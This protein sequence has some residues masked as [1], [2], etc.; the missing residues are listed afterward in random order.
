MTPLRDPA[1][2][3]TPIDQQR[4][5]LDNARLEQRRAA[6]AAR[7]AHAK[8][9]A[10]TRDNSDLNRQELAKA[11]E[12]AKAAGAA[13]DRIRNR[14]RSERETLIGDLA[15]WLAPT[16]EQ[17]IARLSGTMPLVFLP[18]RIET[19]FTRDA[20]LLR[21]Y[22]DDILS[23]SFE[24]ELTDD[25]IAD[26]Q[27]FWATAWPG[28]TEERTAWQVLVNKIG[29]GRAAWVAN[30]MT[31]PNIA[32]RP[33][34][35]PQPATPARREASWTL[36]AEAR[37]LPDRWHVLL[38]S[39]SGERIVS[40]SAIHE[41]LSLTFSPDP[42]DPASPLGDD[43][44]KLSD[45]VRW[46]VDFQEALK[47][48]MALQ[49]SLQGEER[50][51]FS[52]I[53]V[54]GVKSSLAPDVS[55]TGLA[56]MLEHHRYGR[57]VALVPQGTPTN[58]TSSGA[59][60]FPPPDPG[61]Q[62]SFAVER[63]GITVAS[64]R[65]GARFASA[66][67]FAPTAATHLEGADGREFERA[68][69]MARGLWPVT[70]G[71]F[72]TEL[73][74][75]V[76][77]DDDIESARQFFVNHVR[78]RGPLPAFRVG[79]TPYGIV[80]AS[81]LTNWESS[82]SAS[83]AERALPDTFRRARDLWLSKASQIPHVGRSADPDKDL[84]EILATDASAREVRVRPVMGED[85]TW[86]LMGM[87]GWPDAWAYWFDAG[88]LNATLLFTLL[89]HP[90]WRPKVARLNFDQNAWPFK[91]HLVTEAPVSETDGLSPN[92]IDWIRT[93][94]VPDLIGQS[95]PA[96]WDPP[97]SLLYRLL[98]H[99][100]LLEYQSTSFRLGLRL[101]VFQI[102]QRKE[103]EITGLASQPA[104]LDRVQ[105]MM[106]PI[107]G[108]T[109]TA[110][111]HSF[112][113]DPANA[114]TIVSLFPDEPVVGLRDALAIL[115]IASTAEL[116]RLTGETLDCASHRLDAWITA[117]ATKRLEEM[118]RSSPTGCYLAGY[119]WVEN[120]K[121]KPAGSEHPV[122]LSDGS[123]A[124]RQDGN[125]GYVQAPSMT[126]AAAAAILR[127]GYLS[128]TG[129]DRE[130]YAVDLSS[131]QVRSARFVLDAVREGQSIG[132][133]FGYQFERG[134]HDR[135]LDKWI[136]PFR[137]RYPL[138][139]AK[140]GD[141]DDY[142]D[143]SNPDQPR[144]HIA[145]R[146]VVDGLELRTAFQNNQIPWG[147]F[148]LPTT[149][150][151]RQPIEEELA[152]LDRTVDS[153][154][155]LLL[156]E[157]V[158]QLVK[159]SPS[160]AAA[161]LDAMAQGTVRPPDP[162]IATQ[163]RRGT[164][165]TH[166]V[167]LFTGGNGKALPAGFA[168]A[169]T[170]RALIEP[171]L[172]AW[173]GQLF[174]PAA[175]YKC[176]VEFGKPDAP[177]GST[178]V[179]LDQLALRPIDVLTLVRSLSAP[180]PDST[181][182]AA[183]ELDRRVLEV[184]HG[185]MGLTEETQARIQYGR[186]AAGF[187]PATERTFSDLLELARKADS[188]ITQS[189]PLTPEDLVAED[190]G[191]DAKA[192]D[193]HLAEGLTRAQNARQ[194]LFVAKQAMDPE[195]AAAEAAAEAAPFDLT[196]LR[197]ALRAVAEIGVNGAYPASALE[198]TLDQRKQLIAQAGSV[199]AEASRRLKQADATLTEAAKPE[200]AADVRFLL[201][202]V[203]DVIDSICGAAMPFL[204]RFDPPASAELSNALAHS[205]TAAFIDADPTKRRT[206]IRGFERVAA[207]VRSPLDHWRRLEIVA[208]SLGRQAAPRAIA[209]LP[210]QAGA[211]WAGLP[212]PDETKRPSAGDTSILFYC[213]DTPD[214]TVPWCGLLLDHWTEYIPIPTEQTGV[215]FHY[216]DPGA[217]A[218]Q[219]ILLAVPPV[220]NP[221]TWQLSWII[222]TLKESLD[223]AKVRAVDGELLGDVSQLLPAIELADSTA[224]VTIR[225]SFSS[226][227][228]R[229]AISIKART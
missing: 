89:G 102:D 127:N 23:D 156:A 46:T 178:P 84:M 199:S 125:G 183:S 144:E 82:R 138:V 85:S 10:L 59:A 50:A 185:L 38:Q 151:E 74:S 206:A 194:M 170:P 117:L 217:E 111:V 6:L 184:A 120:L 95:V 96:G 76:F 53:I 32:T 37:L 79:N 161:T 115:S 40:G 130:K 8:V 195:L 208:N 63:T 228:A 118:R 181:S 31:P 157:G 45:D 100:A 9:D 135:V 19:R 33:G 55:A 77:G 56:A 7:D 112:L 188:L 139:A 43:G 75:P 152:L 211:R 5:L 15:G 107:P 109:G 193:H 72:L 91:Y 224:D 14:A 1:I 227:Y 64:G 121:P 213:A 106:Q 52:R 73:M 132:A 41:P 108:V 219:V 13:L 159:G 11:M 218:P 26:G 93:A 187:D 205:T 223:M 123:A 70:W 36:A 175:S 226:A 17:E 229:E 133:V 146:N 176:T 200:H 162:E 191:D 39:V 145:A 154:S 47:V 192:A 150:A 99:S 60:P 169:A 3:P 214:V 92:Y 129:T 136:D 131:A 68:G 81:S 153:V 165:L 24:P 163:P 80:P 203:R 30:A 105:Q 66:F 158:Y 51:G 98:R 137:A 4:A 29:Q 62:R 179:S 21:V 34:G 167:V 128:R 122:R 204:P 57:G 212:F 171:R 83:A 104:G 20:L 22:P 90:E 180:A 49:I 134:L 164:G 101:N 172:D 113:S 42:A 149:A 177:S 186:P 87:W 27:E 174:G 202:A 142:E 54:F 166:K 28:E 114:A 155:D 35:T 190:R 86:N 48:G 216:D 140:S 110:P 173:L 126:H 168:A 12:Q 61:A 189:R 210:Y 141:P 198:S 197:D 225:S 209:Q 215:A 58:N 67:G 119:G 143:P 44:L 124:V 160:V 25:E 65:D 220:S 201:F 71:Y 207:A 94:S 2:G 116:E 222:E 18:V 103:R 147:Q 182:A 97:V 88:Q 78:G 148:G 221:Q 69:A 16:P 196:N